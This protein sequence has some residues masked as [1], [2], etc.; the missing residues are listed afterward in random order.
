MRAPGRTDGATR[1]GSRL[2]RGRTAVAGPRV[3]AG[4]A[5]LWAAPARQLRVH[6]ATAPTRRIAASLVS[7]PRTSRSWRA[8]RSIRAVAAVVR[9]THSLCRVG[10]LTT[11]RVGD[12]AAMIRDGI[13]FSMFV[14]C[15][16]RQRSKR[17][18]R[19]AWNSPGWCATASPCP[20]RAAGHG[21]DR[22][23]GEH[24]MG[25]SVLRI[26]TDVGAL[27]RSMTLQRRAAAIDRYCRDAIG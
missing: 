18:G 3:Q 2:G 27:T 15:A 13:R 16:Y 23:R 22:R 24:W 26:S 12:S 10:P 1:E 7:F 21:R 5:R 20:C 25:S 14:R 11:R 17:P 6:V 8:G 19:R 4:E 9:S